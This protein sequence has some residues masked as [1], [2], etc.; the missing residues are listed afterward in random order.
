[1]SGQNVELFNI[2]PGDASNNDRAVKCM[3]SVLCQMGRGMCWRGERWSQGPVEGLNSSV[4]AADAP[5]V[6][7]AHY[8]PLQVTFQCCSEPSISCKA[9]SAADVRASHFATDDRQS[10]C[11]AQLLIVTCCL[12]PPSV[13]VVRLCV[14]YY[15]TIMCNGPFRH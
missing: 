8:C 7:R 13:S 6:V 11:R 4:S 12:Q 15:C 9:Y 2:G 14:Q 3:S 5:T 10:W 1:M